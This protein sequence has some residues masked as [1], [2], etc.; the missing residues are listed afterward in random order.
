MCN[1]T[2]EKEVCFHLIYIYFP[3][4][5]SIFVSEKKQCSHLDLNWFYYLCV[6]CNLQRLMFDWVLINA[7]L[8]FDLC[9]IMLLYWW[10][11]RVLLGIDFSLIYFF[12][13]GRF[14][15]DCDSRENFFLLFWLIIFVLVFCAARLRAWCGQCRS[16]T[17]HSSGSTIQSSNLSVTPKNILIIICCF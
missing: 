7:W 17:R 13:C 5:F 4:S 14:P 15:L 10:Q 3:F 6:R 9:L 1:R 16:D 12:Y 11:P 8:R 2:V